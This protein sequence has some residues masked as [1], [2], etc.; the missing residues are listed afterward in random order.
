MYHTYSKPKLCKTKCRACCSSKVTANLLVWRCS[1]PLLP[2]SLRPCRQHSSHLAL[3]VLQLQGRN[4]PALLQCGAPSGDGSPA[5]AKTYV[6]WRQAI[7]KES[8]EPE[9]C[10]MCTTGSAEKRRTQACSKGSNNARGHQ[11]S[12]NCLQVDQLPVHAS[13]HG[14]TEKGC[15]LTSAQA[16]GPAAVLYA[17]ACATPQ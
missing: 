12:H 10:H 14:H 7:V 3:V 15:C 4:S 2:C 1:L 16:A 9:A 8:R 6:A 11:K 17:S 5:Q 13:M